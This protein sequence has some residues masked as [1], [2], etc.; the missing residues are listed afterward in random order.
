[1]K[2]K[3]ILLSVVAIATLAFTGCGAQP[4]IPMSCELGYSGDY[5]GD[6]ICRDLKSLDKFKGLTSVKGNLDL[7]GTYKDVDGLSNLEKIDGNLNMFSNELTNVN[8]FKNLKEA[9]GNFSI[10]G[11]LENI[12][13]LINLKEIEGSVYL[14]SRSLINLDGFINLKEV[15]GKFSVQGDS[16][17]SVKGLSNLTSVGDNIS[18]KERRFSIFSR[19]LKDITGIGNLNIDGPYSFDVTTMSYGGKEGGFDVKLKHNSKL[20]ETIIPFKSSLKRNYP[21]QFGYYTDYHD[22]YKFI[23]E[24]K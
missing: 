21:N 19:N 24:L 22:K 18:E 9:K 17:T 13:G 11:G 16:L 20:C 4:Q 12:D 6:I 10:R 2:T 8:G 15:G 1:M 3:T 5:K 7:V 14:S 23:C